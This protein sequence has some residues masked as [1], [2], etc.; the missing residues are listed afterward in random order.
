[1]VYFRK[2][3][4]VTPT[5]AAALAP[6]MPVK[7]FSP[8]TCRI[9]HDVGARQASAAGVSTS[10]GSSDAIHCAVDAYARAVA[11]Q[12]GRQT[13]GTF[14][15]QNQPGANG[16]LSATSVLK[17]P[18]DGHTL[19]VGTQSMATINPSA[20]ARLPWK[21]SDFHPIVKGVAAPL[22]LVTHPSVPART[23]PELAQWVAANPGKASYASFSPGTPSHF[24][25]FQL[26]EKLKLDMVHVPYKGSAPQVNDLV[27]GQVLLGFTQL[28]TAVPHIQAG[29]LHAIAV[30]SAAR[31]RFLPEVPTFTELGQ[32]ELTTSIWFGLL[33]PSAT[34]A[35]LVQ[36]ITAAAVKAQADPALRA[37]LEAQN[38]DVPSESGSAFA[39]AI[40]AESAQWAR[41]VKATGFNAN[42]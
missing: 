27:G 11:D 39:A 2:F 35:P 3:C 18:A 8:T 10:S 6:L 19:W 34:P 21:P 41:L 30:T 31:S 12:L 42:D 13:G 16:N 20:Y 24:L 33:A 4:G 38:F 26:N 40:A 29:K 14:L 25:G 37:R 1:M 23:L 9:S 32:P 22:V 28:Q 5:S 36:A 17:A 7:L 15:V